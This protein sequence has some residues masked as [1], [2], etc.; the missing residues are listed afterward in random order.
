MANLR[1]ARRSPPAAKK[2]TYEYTPGLVGTPV[3][4]IA[5]DEQSSFNYDP[6]SAQLTLSQNTQ[7]ELSFNYNNSGQLLKELWKDERTGKHWESRYTYTLTGRPLTR[8]DVDGLTCTYAYDEKARLK[9]VTQGQL[10]ATF[11][12][13][14]LG[15]VCKT[16]TS[17]TYSKQAMTTTLAFDGPGPGSL[18]HDG[19]RRSPGANH[20]PGLPR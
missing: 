2:I 15:R 17:N 10:V 18:P 1:S 3:G 14:D 5:P 19:A 7:G 8:L 20:H 11:D 12:Y 16:T 6:Q 13:D 4:S 9:S